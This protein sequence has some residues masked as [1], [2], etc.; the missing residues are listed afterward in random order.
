M[1]G[2]TEE[3]VVEMEGEEEVTD[4][5]DLH[6]WLMVEIDLQILLWVDNFFF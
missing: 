4:Y 2:E 1:E 6:T 5:G 3:D